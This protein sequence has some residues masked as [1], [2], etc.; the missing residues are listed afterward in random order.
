MLTF[1]FVVLIINCCTAIS[2][3]ERLDAKVAKKRRND[4]HDAYPKDFIL[5]SLSVLRSQATATKIFL[6]EIRSTFKSNEERLDKMEV[7]LS[8]MNAKL[9]GLDKMEDRLTEMNAKLHGLE[10][11]M[12]VSLE[13][14]DVVREHVALN[15]E[16]MTE[17]KSG[18]V[19]SRQITETVKAR[20]NVMLSEVRLISLY[21]M[22]EQTTVH[23][24]GHGSDLAV[25]GQFV[26][27]DWAP[28]TTTRAISHTDCKPNQK[29]SIDLG[30]LFRIHRVKI[31]MSRHA[32]I[33]HYP[34][35]FL[36]VRILADEKLLGVTTTL[37]Y[38]YDFK[39]AENDPTYAKSVT[40]HRIEKE[41]LNVIEIQVWGTGPFAEDDKFA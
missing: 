24:D 8:E 17:V 18:I 13:K 5:E 32:T 34:S 14:T 22:T 12:K 38:I 41:C 29:I 1:V 30:A 2:Q 28:S 25:D 9:H 6:E 36:G 20:Q 21:K 27:S 15:K 33:A 4:N 10:T 7:R 3:T 40:M 19:A 16:I 37:K 11:T 31:W 26:F 23:V 35:R 39:V